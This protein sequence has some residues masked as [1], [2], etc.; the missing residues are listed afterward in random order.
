MKNICTHSRNLK[1]ALSAVIV[2]V[3]VAQAAPSLAASCNAKASQL[4]ASKGGQVLSVTTQGNSCKI[5]LLVRSKKG[6][7]K[8]QTFVVRK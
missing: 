6:P 3:F 5:K 7:P 4:A 1:T 8:R 2:V